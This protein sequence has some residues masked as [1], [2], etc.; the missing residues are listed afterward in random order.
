MT[1]QAAVSRDDFEQLKEDVELNKVNRQYLYDIHRQTE[2]L[3]RE[4]S[5][6]SAVTNVRLQRL[7]ETA[8]SCVHDL[9][10]LR[11]DHLLQADRV[12]KDNAEIKSTLAKI[13]EKLS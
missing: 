8:Q 9:T 11:R 13:L 4:F 3:C 12:E 5:D 6:F 1:T 10:E 7:E 2:Q